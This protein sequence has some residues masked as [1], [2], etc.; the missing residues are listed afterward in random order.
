MEFLSKLT[1]HVNKA[2]KTWGRSL[3]LPYAN[4]AKF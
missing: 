3:K 4:E 1:F 2:F